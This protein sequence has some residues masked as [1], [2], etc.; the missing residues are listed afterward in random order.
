MAVPDATAALTP[1]R[2]RADVAEA[3][4]E[5]PED[6][7][8]ADDLLDRGL[9]SIRLMSLVERWRAEGAEVGFIDLADTPTLE[10]WTRLLGSPR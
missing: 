6:L 7:D 1:E 10:A 8:E 2:I 4:G 9:D 5:P 3:L